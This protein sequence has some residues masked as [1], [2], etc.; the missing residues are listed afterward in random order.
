MSS[1]PFFGKAKVKGHRRNVRERRHTEKTERSK[2][3][4]DR[5]ITHSAVPCWETCRFQNAFNNA[6][7]KRPAVQVA[8]VP[9]NGDVSI[10]QQV[11]ITY[12][13]FIIG[14]SRSERSVTRAQPT[15]LVRR[16]AP[17]N[18]GDLTYAGSS[19][20]RVCSLS[21]KTLPNIC[22][23]EGENAEYSNFPLASLVSVNQ[24]LQHPNTYVE[25]HIC[26]PAR[27]GKVA[28]GLC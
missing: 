26:K 28:S 4:V 5:L 24:Q 19:L 18:S 10:H 23:E 3:V 14:L 27:Q 7:S 20:K 6:C 9:W 16:N 15:S 13:V 17:R 8:H 11:V 12:H 2:E 25:T 21:K 22:V 1:H